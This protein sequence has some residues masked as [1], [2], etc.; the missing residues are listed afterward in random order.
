MKNLNSLKSQN[1]KPVYLFISRG[2]GPAKSPLIKTIYHTV[3]K[4]YRQVPM[5]PEKPI[6]LLAVFTGVAAINIDGTTIN[7]AL[8]IPKNTGDCLPAMS[9]QS[10]QKRTQMRLSLCELKGIIIDEI[11]MVGNTTLLHIH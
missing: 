10:D 11:S 4:T 3:V 7:T 1:V 8:A 6:E 9:D 2:D 5:N